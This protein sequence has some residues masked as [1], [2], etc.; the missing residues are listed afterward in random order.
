MDQW[1]VIRLRCVRDKEPIKRVARELGLAPNTV[2]KY[3]RTQIVPRK[4][5]I[6][7]ERRLD[8]FRAVIDEYLRTTP[9][10]TA[11]RIGVLLLE[12]HDAQ[13][14]VCERALRQY[15]AMRRA[16]LTPKEAFV[17][18]EYQPGD[19]AQFDFSPMRAIIAG[20]EQKLHV[21]A[22]RLSYSTHFFA[23][24]SMHEDQPALFT[25]LLDGLQFFDGLP[26][27]AVFDNAKTAVQRVL[28]GRNREQNAQFREFCG[29]L[30]LQVEFAAPRRGNEKGGVEGLMGYIEDNFFR[31][32]PQ[33]ESLADLN[34]A[35]G[36]FCVTEL[37]REHSTHRE[38][39][40]TRFER[41]APHLR[42]L[43]ARRRSILGPNP[44]GEPHDFSDRL[45]SDTPRVAYT[46][47]V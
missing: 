24:A 26:R 23:R 36:R 39:V 38:P 42:P 4:M 37:Q 11:R 5:T 34:T 28:R 9:K 10:I 30:A 3:V 27:V 14:R 8:R 12:R 2:R 33:F 18:A 40:A 20:V 16:A 21:F 46:E 22:M 35:L 6:C 45:G 31:P 25:G 15:V 13:L 7:R 43:P 44:T 47:F 29:S 1:E 17:R 32:V 41:E 19:Q